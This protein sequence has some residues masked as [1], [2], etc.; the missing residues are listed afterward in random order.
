VLGSVYPVRH[1]VTIVGAF[2]DRILSST[3]DLHPYGVVPSTDSKARHPA[4]LRVSRQ[5]LSLR[6]SPPAATSW[7]QYVWRECRV[8]ILN[9]CRLF[10]IRCSPP[11]AKPHLARDGRSSSSGDGARALVETGS[12]RTYVWS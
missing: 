1:T 12:A 8:G 5:H 4:C 10:R 3:T 6:T 7:P 9:G 2:D 11:W